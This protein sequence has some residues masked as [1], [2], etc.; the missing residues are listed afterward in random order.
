MNSDEQKI[1]CPGCLTDQPGQEAHMDLGGCLYAEY[2]PRDEIM[3]EAIA[4]KI[5]KG[6]AN[7]VTLKRCYAVVPGESAETYKL[8]AAKLD[9]LNATYKTPPAPK[10]KKL[11]P[12]PPPSSPPTPIMMRPLFVP[13]YR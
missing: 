7:A 8:R 9:E 6:V 3:A 4:A 2:E 12:S 13:G 5:E 1:T 10:K 11:P